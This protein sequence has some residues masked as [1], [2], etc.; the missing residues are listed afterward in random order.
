MYKRRQ[1]GDVVRHLAHRGPTTYT[2]VRLPAHE[3]ARVRDE[4]KA[5]VIPQPELRDERAAVSPAHRC[6]VRGE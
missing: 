1:P 5:V 4:G 3:V 2:A 6:G